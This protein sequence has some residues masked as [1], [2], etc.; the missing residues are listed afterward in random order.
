MKNRL[1]LIPILILFASCGNGEKDFDA[2]GVFEAKEIIVSSEV[3][4][5]I[6]SLNIEEGQEL[7]QGQ[8]YGLIDTLQLYLKRQQLLYSIE[9]I[10]GRAIDVNT[11]IASLKEQISKMKVEKQRIETLLKRNAANQKQLDDINSNI[12]VAEKQLL[13]QVSSF[14]KGNK[15]ISSEEASF[16]VQVLQINDQLEKCKITSPIKG[17][18]LLKYSEQGEVTGVGRPIFKIS[19][20][21]NMI[22]R[23]YIT[24][25]QLTQVKLDQEI[26][27]F[28]DFGKERKEYKGKISWISSKAEFT[29]KSIQV[30]DDRDNLVYAVKVMV[31]NDGYLKIGM[32]GDVK[33]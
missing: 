7:E 28:A 3:N 16:R 5:R 8:E 14:E 6:L 11:Q 32:Y 4:G 31:K 10:G 20:V 12:S 33:L 24:S 2:S 25:S 22:L 9:A 18:V 23:I 13:A 26:K 29:P 21:D 27:V 19:D 15:S 1:L 30:K 17:R